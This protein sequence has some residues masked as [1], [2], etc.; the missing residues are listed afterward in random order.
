M[1]VFALWAHTFLFLLLI[2]GALWNFTGLGFGL[3]MALLA[4]QAYLTIGLKG[5]FR[6]SW[7]AAALKGAAHSVLYLGLLWGPLVA[8]FFI[9]QA[10]GRLPPSYW[11]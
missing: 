10:L 3:A 8:A 11:E 7:P 5:Y 4:Y 1:A 2:L 9:F 6:T